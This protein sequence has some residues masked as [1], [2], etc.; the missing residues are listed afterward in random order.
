MNLILRFIP[1]FIGAGIAYFVTTNIMGFDKTIKFIITSI[2][3]LLLCYFF[4]AYNIW[5]MK[6]TGELSET[7]VLAPNHLGHIVNFIG[8]LCL[9]YAFIENNKV[10]ILVSLG[11]VVYA[12]TLLTKTKLISVKRHQSSLNKVVDP[13]EEALMRAI[14]NQKNEDPLVGLKIGSNEIIQRLLAALKN[15]KGVHVESL[16]AIIG[17]LAG[18]SCHAAC[19]EELVASTKMTEKEAFKIVSCKDGKNYYFGDLPNKPLAEDKYSVWSLVAGTTQHLGGE[20]YD[21][22]STFSNSIGAMGSEYFGIPQVPEQHRPNDTPLNYV[23]SLWPSLL[24]ILDKFCARPMERP[25]LLGLVAQK[26]I[27]MG[28]EVIPPAIAAKLVMECAVPMSKIGPEWLA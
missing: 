23:K 25:I 18:Y 19:R 14:N 12:D 6:R 10:L 15:D 1:F 9:G 4:V 21:I 17:S 11:L 5:M 22:K 2:T 24:P 13:K 7:K 26:A 20:L 8:A 27:E 3:M 28:K 16:L